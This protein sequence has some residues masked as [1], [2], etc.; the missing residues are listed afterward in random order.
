MRVAWVHPSWRDLVIDYLAHHD[1]VRARYLRSSSIHGTLLALSAEGGADGERRLPL[2]RR[3]RDWDAVSD[4]VF[5][6]APDLE[7]AELIG[8]LGSVRRTIIDV[9]D[10]A[11]GVE[12]DALART[13]LTR[14]SALW[15]AAAHA[16]IP[17]PELA[18]WFELA[19][20]LSPRPSA[21]PVAGTWVDLVPVGTPDILDRRS[22]ERFADWLSLAQL[23]FSHDRQLL[24]DLDFRDYP[25]SPILSFIN[26]LAGDDSRGQLPAADP[27]RRA[28]DHIGQLFPALVEHSVTW[29]RASRRVRHAEDTSPWGESPTS[30]DAPWSERSDVDRVLLDL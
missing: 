4:R 26:T 11:A 1:A 5:E 18:A 10:T 3:D 12:A 2:L 23:L 7:P 14:V 28:L 25:S 24:S 21:P 17:I 30:L 29:Q 8:L 27:A 16:P 22:L 9:K 15:A 20:I 19:G 6:L 13:V